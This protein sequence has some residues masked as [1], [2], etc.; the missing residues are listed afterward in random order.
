MGEPQRLVPVVQRHER[1]DGSEYFLVWVEELPAF[2]IQD[3]SRERALSLLRREVQSLG[4]HL[5]MPDAYVAFL[6]DEWTYREC[7]SINDVSVGTF[8][9]L[10]WNG[11]SFRARTGVTPRSAQRTLWEDAQQE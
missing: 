3:D 8:V 1:E 5:G 2:V 9:A 10:G 11:K 7:C 4:P 6:P